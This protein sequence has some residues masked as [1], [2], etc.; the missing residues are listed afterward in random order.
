[1]I[2]TIINKGEIKI[3]IPN[4]PPQEILKIQEC[5]IGLLEQK[6]FN[7]MNGKVIMHFKDGNLMEVWTVEKKWRRKAV[8]KH[9]D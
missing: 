6:F 8:D 1:M 2:Q 5:I 3:E 4:L 7:I 9:K